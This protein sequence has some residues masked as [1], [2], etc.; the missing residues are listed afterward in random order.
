MTNVAFFSNKTLEEEAFVVALCG[1][2]TAEWETITFIEGLY[3]GGYYNL[4]LTTYTYDYI[5]LPHALCNAFWMQEYYAL[6]P[7]I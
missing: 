3:G 1:G 5:F 7:N 4:D 2:D 6:N